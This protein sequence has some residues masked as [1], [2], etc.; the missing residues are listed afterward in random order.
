MRHMRKPGRLI[1]GVLGTAGLF[2]LSA[3]CTNTDTLTSLA[4]LTATTA[5]NLVQILLKGYLEN[6]IARAN[7]DPNIPISRQ[8]H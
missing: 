1:C 2:G 4:D 7:P 3:G 8:L 5:G 6:Q